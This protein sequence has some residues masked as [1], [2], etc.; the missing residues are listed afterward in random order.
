M[1]PEERKHPVILSS[2][3]IFTKLQFRRYH[4]DLLHGGPTAIIAHSGNLFYVIGA[5]RLA[6]SVCQTC[7]ICRK[8]AAKAG[9]QLMGQLP[10][11]RLN[12]DFVFFHTGLDYAG[13]YFL[14]EGIS[15]DQSK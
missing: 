3:D 2:K 14:K 5:R 1:I 11:S 7:I 8:A 13:P 6:R 10:P 12:P 4:L 9:P 15:E